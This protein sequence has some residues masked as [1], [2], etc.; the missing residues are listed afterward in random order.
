LN[1]DYLRLIQL[2]TL[3]LSLGSAVYLFALNSRYRPTILLAWAF[4]GSTVFYLAMV[5]EFAGPWYWR[6]HNLKTLLQPLLQV[7][8]PAMFFVALLMF[9]YS[10]PRKGPSREYRVILP[11]FVMLNIGLVV[12]TF[13]NIVILQR[14]RSIFRLESAYY[15]TLYSAVGLQFATIVFLLL[16]NTARFSG[17]SSEPLWKRL[18]LPR[19]HITAAAGATRAMSL[20]LLVP[21]SAII[22]WLMRYWRILPGV[23][24][25]YL[26]W[27]CFL[28]FQLGLVVAY[29]NHTEDPM[30]FR[31]K[32]VAGT[33]V[34]VLGILSVVVVL[35]GHT[36]ESD[37]ENTNLVSAEQTI[38]FQP[39]EFGS[40]DIARRPIEFDPTPGR[41]LLIR[42]GGVRRWELPFEFPF[43]GVG[44]GTISIL[45]G[46][47]IYLGEDIREQGWGGYHPQPVIAPIIMNLDPTRG[48]GVFIETRSDR[49]TITW[50]ALPELGSTNK[51]TIQLRLCADGCFSF[52][53]RK[54]DPDPTCRADKLHVQTTA[55]LISLDP[56]AHGG[57][58]STR[59]PPKLV[60]IHPGGA[61]ATLEPIRFMDDLPYTSDGPAVIF[62]AYDI[63]YYRYLNDRM[64]P[65]A[66]I[67]VAAAALVVF[68]FPLVLRENIIKPLRALYDGMHRVEQGDLHVTLTPRF[69][70]EVGFLSRSFNQMLT[71]IRRMEAG[72]RSL[73]D[74]AHD[75]ILVLRED[76]SPAYANTRVSEITG[77]SHTEVMETSFGYLM[78]H[79]DPAA[80]TEDPLRLRADHEQPPVSEGLPAPPHYETSITNSGGLR[81][82]VDISVSRTLWL[83]RAARVIIIRD[84]RARRHDEERAREQQQEL[85]R[86]DKLT[87]LGVLASVMAHDI[88]KPTQ[89]IRLNIDF[90]QRACPDLLVVLRQ[91]KDEGYLVGG[92]ELGEFRTRLQRLPEI[93]GDCSRNIEAIVEN[94]SS[95]AREESMALTP[96]LDING[97]I[98]SAVRMVS[99]FINRATSRFALRLGQNIPA[100]TGNAQRVEQVLINLILNACQALPDR[101]AAIN[102]STEFDPESDRVEIMV[103]DQGTGISE[104]DIDHVTELFFTTR[105]HLGGT[106]LGLWVCERIVE[107]HGGILSFRSVVSKGTTAVVSLPRGVEI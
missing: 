1:L 29:L 89:V 61:E 8:G 34:A 23:V 90:L 86:T 47:M 5:L 40:Y 102:V 55:G 64:A 68:V 93:M 37:Y 2:P 45:H 104:E 78:T 69:N 44:Y 96:G 63:D 77:Y 36:Y 100:I 21:L 24:T 4:V 59:F 28:V 13:Y 88:R 32:I 71:A 95:F 60:G 70:D 101:E 106:G 43:F 67:I 11:L 6:P 62:E 12:F 38:W 76:G 50:L 74:N 18:L 85:M 91:L 19:G 52:S 83:G 105:R 51:N 16:R 31:V 65:L 82:P 26:V 79:G 57:E 103:E 27:F 49:V 35:V 7:T 94:W 33:L 99:T 46:P 84:I 42:V 72:F 25:A 56:G 98:G 73:A 15:L 81:V 3:I 107:E 75:G 14:M 92:L 30:G 9:S 66:I 20:V 39:N 87:S 41:R 17:R 10:F 97:V 53:Y 48:R 54:L 58:H 80:D 22:V